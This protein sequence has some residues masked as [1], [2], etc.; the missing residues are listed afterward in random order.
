MLRYGLVLYGFVCVCIK[1]H[2]EVFRYGIP[3]YKYFNIFQNIIKEYE[4][5]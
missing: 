2:T 5:N 4:L 1:N 3:W